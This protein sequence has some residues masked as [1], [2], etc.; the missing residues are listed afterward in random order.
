MESVLIIFSTIAEDV[1]IR[2]LSSTAAQ[3]IFQDKLAEPLMDA[4]GEYFEWLRQNI[5][6]GIKMAGLTIAGQ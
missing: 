3:K 5:Q 2:D 4:I 6:N 1:K